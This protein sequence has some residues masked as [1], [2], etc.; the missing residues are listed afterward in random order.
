MF[1]STKKDKYT[2]Q[3][4]ELLFLINGIK[5]CKWTSLCTWYVNFCII[6]P[7]FYISKTDKILQFFSQF[8]RKFLQNFWGNRFTCIVDSSQQCRYREVLFYDS[9]DSDRPTEETLPIRLYSP[10]CVWK[11]TILRSAMNINLKSTFQCQKSL[12]HIST[13]NIDEKK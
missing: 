11:W 13:T 4:L 3:I 6:Y 5:K 7:H 9:K 8:S 10:F 12:S 2:M 1:Q